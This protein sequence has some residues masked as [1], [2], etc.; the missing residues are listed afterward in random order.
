MG[1]VKNIFGLRQRGANNFFFHKK[2]NFF[3]SKKSYEKYIICSYLYLYISILTVQIPSFCVKSFAFDF[4]IFLLYF[5]VWKKVK[6][7]AKLHL[8]TDL[9]VAFWAGFI[10]IRRLM[11]NST[12]HSL[13]FW[14]RKTDYNQLHPFRAFKMFSGFDNFTL[15]LVEKLAQTVFRTFKL[16]TY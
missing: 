6:K 9:S 13:T 10:N 4:T 8:K 14:G 15:T 1:S 16:E 7:L 12:K 5:Q 3:F 11:L 2:C